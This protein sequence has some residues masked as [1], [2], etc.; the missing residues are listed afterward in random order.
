MNTEVVSLFQKLGLTEYESKTISAMVRRNEATAQQISDIAE[1]P[2]TK[3]YSVLTSL[4]NQGLIKCTFERPKKFKMLQP[5]QI[6]DLVLKRKKAEVKDLEKTVSKYVGY[7]E[8]EYQ[9][10][11]PISHKESVWVIPNRELLA[12]EAVAYVGETKES[13]FFMARHLCNEIFKS[14]SSS[15]VFLK[16]AERGTKFQIIMSRENPINWD[17]MSEPAIKFLASDNVSIR[18]LNEKSM[19]QGVMY[20]DNK[21]VAFGIRKNGNRVSKSLVIQNDLV[22]QSVRDYLNTMWNSSEHIENEIRIQAMNIQ[23]AEDM[24]QY[25]KEY[26]KNH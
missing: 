24:N 25:S 11:S 1:V 10:A 22:A 16:N 9:N 26:R 20:F 8:E 12:E 2:I 21:I 23:T 14:K 15:N 19:P 7:L 17:K 5:S 3:I 13:S 4:E 6:V 18:S